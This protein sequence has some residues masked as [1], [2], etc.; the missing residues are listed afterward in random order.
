MLLTKFNLA[1]PSSCFRQD[2]DEWAQISNLGGIRLRDGTR[3][4]KPPPVFEEDKERALGEIWEVLR[5][6]PDADY[7]WYTYDGKKLVWSIPSDEP[8]AVPDDS[9]RTVGG[10][11]SI[12]IRDEKLNDLGI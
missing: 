12:L 8:Q 4:K 6:H 1:F 10:M 9:L 11:A 3:L 2:F 5:E 7:F